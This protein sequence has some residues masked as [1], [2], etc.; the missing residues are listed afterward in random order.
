MTQINLI[1]IDNVL[2]PSVSIVDAINTV[3]L[4]Q[5][6]EIIKRNFF[7]PVAFLLVAFVTSQ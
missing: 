3:M 4:F 5:Y 1:Q 2:Y 7:Q 6:K